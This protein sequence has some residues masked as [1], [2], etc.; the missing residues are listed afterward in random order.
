MRFF[1]FFLCFFYSFFVCEVVSIHISSIPFVPIPED[2]TCRVKLTGNITEVMCSSHRSTGGYITKIDKDHFIDNRTGEVKEFKHIENRA[3]DKQNVAKSLSHGRDV[4]NANVIFPQN[5]R[6]LTLTY[7]E[8]MTDTKRLLSNFRDFNK[9]CRALYGHYEY[10]ACCEPQAR[11]A[12][13]L[14]VILIFSSVAPFMANDAVSKA[15]KQGFVSVRALDNVD[16][17]GAYLTAYLG[18]M[19]LDEID[20]YIGDDCEVKEVVS[21]DD[22][23]C[24]TSKK[25]VKGARLSLYPAGFHIFR[26]SKGIKMPYICEMPYKDIKKCVSPASLTHSRSICLDDDFSDYHNTISYEY[27]NSSKLLYLF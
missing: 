9:R 16:N 7:R 20:F 6:W 27:Y 15:W 11:G 8:N 23:F 25:I 22:N 1:V 5:C 3:Q 14:H 17:V 12:W 10:I 2:D 4:I 19:P 18:D 24:S 13:H 21:V 26:Y